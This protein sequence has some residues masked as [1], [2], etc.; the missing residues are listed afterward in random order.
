MAA[1][2]LNELYSSACLTFDENLDSIGLEEATQSPVDTLQSSVR[3]IGLIAPVS[4]LHNLLPQTVSNSRN[5]I[6]QGVYD[7]QAHSDEIY[8]SLW[9]GQN[10][11]SISAGCQSNVSHRVRYTSP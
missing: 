6:S 2:P 10:T 8:D 4:S 1:N 3:D 11:Q 5:Q 9:P 7:Q